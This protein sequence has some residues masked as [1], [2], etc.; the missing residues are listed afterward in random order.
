MSVA[1]FVGEA[2]TSTCKC[3]AFNQHVNPMTLLPVSYFD[4]QAEKTHIQFFFS[5]AMACCLCDEKYLQNTCITLAL[6]YV[7]LTIKFTH[8]FPCDQ[9]IGT[10]T[11]GCERD[12]TY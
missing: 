5:V 6:T 12:V 7:S 1:T 4:V 2:D 3:I 8:F 10:H 11:V 9:N